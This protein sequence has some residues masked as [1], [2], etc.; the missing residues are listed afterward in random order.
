MDGFICSSAKQR[1]VLIRP[2]G[3]FADTLNQIGLAA[4]YCAKHERQ[5]L[6]DTQK[7]GL[8][9]SFDEYFFFSSDAPFKWASIS[10]KKY[11]E[12]ENISDVHPNEH[13]GRIFQYECSE[14]ARGATVCLSPSGAVIDFDQE[15]AYAET[16]LVRERAGGG[17]FGTTFIL[18]FIRLQP[19][20][21][22]VLKQRLSHLPDDYLAAHL[23]ATDIQNDVPKLTQK[24]RVLGRGRHVV[25]CADNQDIA[26]KLVRQVNEPASM[27]RLTSIEDLGGQPLHLGAVENIKQN[28]IEMLLDLFA[29]ARSKVIIFTLLDRSHNPLFGA[30]IS[31]FLR[32]GMELNLR[33]GILASMMDACDSPVKVKRFSEL[34]ARLRFFTATLRSLRIDYP[35][36]RVML[37]VLLGRS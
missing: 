27:V 13:A 10:A 1:M 7:S 5:L 22:R 34:R 35:C 29:L 33:P 12:L 11:E 18:P 8:R 2:R 30:M 19:R 25:L 15:L 26:T 9:D 31:G 28:N 24:I 21:S 32:L 17:M 14:S 37:S 16:L 6:I 36:G 20:V 3:G 4:I 23:R